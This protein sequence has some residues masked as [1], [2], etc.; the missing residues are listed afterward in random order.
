MA[1][2]FVFFS[3]KDAYDPELRA[4]ATGCAHACREGQKGVYLG[5]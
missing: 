5:F 4:V 2:A 3:M 1:S